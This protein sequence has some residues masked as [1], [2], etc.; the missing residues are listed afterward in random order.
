MGYNKKL[1]GRHDTFNFRDCLKQDYLVE[2]MIFGW[3]W[4][5]IVSESK[6]INIYKIIADWVIIYK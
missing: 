2:V 6:V 4:Y 1:D 3:A 5:Y